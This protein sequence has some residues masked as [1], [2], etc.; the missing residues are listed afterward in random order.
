MLCQILIS[1]HL[2]IGFLIDYSFP[3]KEFIFSFF[4]S[5]LVTLDTE[6]CAIMLF[7]LWILYGLP[8]EDKDILYF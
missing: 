1:R 5:H 7:I 3:R 2:K 4:V 8:K 6:H